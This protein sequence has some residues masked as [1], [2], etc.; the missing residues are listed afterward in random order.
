MGLPAVKK[1]KTGYSTDNDV[2]KKLEEEHDIVSKIIEYRAL[3]KL[4]ST[5][6][7]GLIPCIDEKTKRVHSTFHQT[8]TTT[9][10][11]SST[12]PNL[13]NIPTRTA[14]GRVLRKAF[15]PEAGNIYIDADYSQIELRI[16]AHISEDENMIE[17]FR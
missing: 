9:G 12:E 8:V 3:S 2:L 11:I 15:K 14:E 10:R 16:L 17:A 13:Q 5:Y 7:E 1:T 6:V 4:N